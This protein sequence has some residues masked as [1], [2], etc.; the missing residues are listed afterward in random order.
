MANELYAEIITATNLSPKGTH[1]F[2]SI[3]NHT[4]NNK[5][6]LNTVNRMIG[7]YVIKQRCLLLLLFFISIVLSKFQIVTQN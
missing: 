1:N 7:K 4:A 6:G 5:Y 2:S 3:Q